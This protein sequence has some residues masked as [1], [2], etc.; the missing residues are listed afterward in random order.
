LDARLAIGGTL[1]A[2]RIVEQRT[3]LVELVQGRTTLG[4]CF[5]QAGGDGKTPFAG[6]LGLPRAQFDLSALALDACALL[7]SVVLGRHDWC[8]QQQ[9]RQQPDAT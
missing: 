4:A 9:G 8:G 6:R 1:L 5:G 2:L 7:R 3:L